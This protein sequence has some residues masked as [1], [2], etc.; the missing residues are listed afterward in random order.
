MLPP[1]RCP[2][3]AEEQAA[4]RWVVQLP[5]RRSDLKAPAAGGRWLVRGGSLH[6][7]GG[8]DTG[9]CSLLSA[10]GGAADAATDAFTV[11]A[12]VCPAVV[13][14]RTVKVCSPT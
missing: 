10:A 6:V 7:G 2:S 11:S 14:A 4:A 8:D 1:G 5:S 13:S 12:A 3:V 9:P